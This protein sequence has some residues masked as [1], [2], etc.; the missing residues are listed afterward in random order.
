MDHIVHRVLRFD[1]FALDLARGCLRAGDQEIDLR[2]KTFEVLCYLTEN[3]GRLVS[4]RQLFEA[5]WPNVNVCD[6]SLVQCI[7]ELRQRLGDDEH[8]LIKTV[9]RRGYLLDASVSARA[10]QCLSDGFAAKLPEGA[11]TIATEPVVLLDAARTTLVAKLGKWGAVAASLVCVALGATYLFG[12]QV[13]LAN[14]GANAGHVSFAANAPPEPQS[15]PTFKDCADCPEMVALPTGEFLMGS[16]ANE[17]GR[18]SAEGKPRRV[19]IKKPIAIGKFEVTIDQFSAF[20][21]ETGQ[22]AGDLCSPVIGQNDHNGQFVWGPPGASFRQP[23]FAVTGTHPAVCISWHDAQAYVAWLGRRTGKPYRLPTEAEWEYAARAGTQTA[24]SFGDDMTPL[25]AFARTTDVRSRL[26]S[27]DGCRRDTAGAFPV[28]Q[29]KP[30]P[31]GI[32]DV[33]GNAWEW[34]EDCWTPD[35]S[36]IPADGSAYSLPSGCEDGVTRGGS[37]AIG[38]WRL[39][40]ATRTERPMASRENHVGFRVALSLGG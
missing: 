34:V 3:A 38:P 16:P 32:F 23:G 30:N 29:L 9:S 22:T 13:P 21:A 17:R 6:D 40:S 20:V 39:R 19:V 8:R 1:R 11:E 24:Y 35:S 5:V 25:C 4:K 15:R 12:R 28:G 27:R 10:P 14:P 7:R 37:W 36:E 2:P 31:W 26:P 33:H 18:E